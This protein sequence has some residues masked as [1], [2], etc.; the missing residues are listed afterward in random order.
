MLECHTQWKYVEKDATGK[1]V[2]TL[3]GRMTAFGNPTLRRNVE[4]REEKL[5]EMYAAL[6]TGDKYELAASFGM[7]NSGTSS[8]NKR[9]NF[10]KFQPVDTNKVLIEPGRQLLGFCVG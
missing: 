10:K 3:Y 9:F 7:G 6:I 2:D 1:L 5:M 4:A 8:K